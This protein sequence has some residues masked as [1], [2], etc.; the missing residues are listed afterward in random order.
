MSTISVCICRQYKWF[1]FRCF[2]T[3]FFKS[4]IIVDFLYLSIRK[5]SNKPDSFNFRLNI[6]QYCIQKTELKDTLCGIFLFVQS[7]IQTNRDTLTYYVI[8]LISILVLKF[9]VFYIIF[10]FINIIYTN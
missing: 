10:Y 9:R 6:F 7:F 5:K 2:W 1:A 8:L 3:D 4:F